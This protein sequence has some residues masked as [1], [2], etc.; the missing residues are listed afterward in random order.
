M[1]ADRQTN[2]DRHGHHHTPLLYW[3]QSNK[4]GSA[5]ILCYEQPQKTTTGIP[6][7]S[8]LNAVMSGVTPYW[9]ERV[10]FPK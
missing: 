9:G 8:S 6:T 2:T 10:N 4:T 1:I 5:I 7:E 3:G